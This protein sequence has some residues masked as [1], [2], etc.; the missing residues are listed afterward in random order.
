MKVTVER[1]FGGRTLSLTTG[2][3]AKQAS[4]AVL[5]RHGDT[6]LFVAAQGGPARPGIDFFPLQVDY[7]ERMA[8][9]G[10]FDS[11]IA[12]ARGSRITAQER[13]WLRRVER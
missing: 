1:E 7:R 9:A 3:I 2:E 8:A 6:V 4:G 11:V 12:E 5:V 10:R 13:R